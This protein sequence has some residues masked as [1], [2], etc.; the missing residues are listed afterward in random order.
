MSLRDRC[1][2]AVRMSKSGLRRV[3]RG[4]LRRLLRRDGSTPAP[5]PAPAVVRTSAR[6][7]CHPVERAGAPRAPSPCCFRVL[8]VGRPGNSEPACM[9]YR[10]YNVIEALRQIGVQS[11]FVDDRLLPARLGEVLAYDLLVLV[12]RRR[13]PEIDTILDFADSHQIPVVCDLDDYLFDREVLDQ[14]EYLRQ[15]PAGNAETLINQFRYLV[16]RCRYYTGSTSFLTERAASLGASAF[17]IR[18]G[19]NTTQLEMS[20]I[21]R[22]TVTPARGGPELWLGY[23]SGTMTHQSDFGLIADVVVS[24]LREFETVGLVV[25]GDLKLAEFPEF[26]PVADRVEE[27]PFVDWTRLP[28]EIARVDINLIPLVP[29]SFTEA[30]SDLKYYEAAILKIPSVATATEVFRSCITHG[31]NGFV[32]RT[33]DEWRASLR[34][35]ITD[36]GLRRAMG[37]KAYEHAL[38]HYQPKSIGEQARNA[39]RDI[40]LDHRMRLGVDDGSPTVVV[41][42]SD[43]SRAIS[44][45]SPSLA[46]CDELAKAGA[47]VTLHLDAQPGG[48]DAAHALLTMR[49]FLAEPAAFTVQMGGEMPCADIVLAT[50]AR[51]AHDVW[52]SQRAARWRAYLVS[53]FEPARLAD[54]P[55]RA[56]ASHS[57]ELGLE[58]VVLDTVVAGLLVKHGYRNITELPI[59]IGPGPREFGGHTDPDTVL[60]VSSPG[61][62]VPDVVWSETQLALEQ[63]RADHPHIRLIAGGGAG[64]LFP[65]GASDQ[66][67]H[68]SELAAPA[69]VSADA[70]APA[71]AIDAGHDLGSILARRP[72]CVVLCPAGRP[73]RVHE[74]A[75]HGCPMIVVNAPDQCTSR[76]AELVHGMV[77]VPPNV[78]AIT[79]AI[80]SVLVDRVRSGALLLHAAEH[81]ASLPGAAEAARALLA[82]YRTNYAA[83]HTVGYRYRPAPFDP[84]HRPAPERTPRHSR[85]HTDEDRLSPRVDRRVG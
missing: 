2:S 45:R 18:N 71:I 59:R 35:L 46:L 47:L 58:L 54:G 61:D 29:S 82:R 10:A 38:D 11:D 57:Y 21:A 64:R 79:R 75:A 24:L 7:W 41:R 78:L 69:G 55:E 22:E 1:A 31:S 6:V 72:V 25:A 77:E 62:V 60:V 9:R 53:E 33:P 37:Q 5:P 70:Q 16:T 3:G 65:A 14:S 19:L 17:V 4:A 49:E 83:E 68:A 39:Y 51:T 50:D 15:Q 76:D 30:K 42:F 80:D 66:N 85:A 73:P 26:A 36:T 48:H 8:F 44:E 13:S 34:S 67:P 63:I 32:V 56:R 52:I 23:F 81:V 12:R 74:L 40:L 20:R 84:A 43:L 28:S 27:R